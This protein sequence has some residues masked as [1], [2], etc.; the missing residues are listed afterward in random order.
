MSKAW[1]SKFRGSSSSTALLK[2]FESK[3]L[4]ANVWVDNLSILGDRKINHLPSGGPSNDS[5][6]QALACSFLEVPFYR[7][8]S[9]GSFLQVSFYMFFS[10]RP[11]LVDPS[12]V[13]PCRL[14]QQAYARL[15]VFNN[16]PNGDSPLQN[17]YWKARACEKV[18]EWYWDAQFENSNL[19]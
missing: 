16:N 11:I 13:E 19:P 10:C 18:I 6:L 12:Y 2:T 17:A 3:G 7:C 8:L 9:A 5:G 14:F 4:S 1:R 15:A